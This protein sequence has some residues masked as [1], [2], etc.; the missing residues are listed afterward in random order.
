MRTRA[1]I[2]PGEIYQL[3]AIFVEGFHRT[4]DLRAVRKILDT[5]D[6]LFYFKNTLIPENM[7]AVASLDEAYTAI[8][9]P[10]YHIEMVTK[11]LRF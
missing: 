11:G 1:P 5:M 4:I 7:V 3:S 6:V 2:G 10:S 9:C 8:K